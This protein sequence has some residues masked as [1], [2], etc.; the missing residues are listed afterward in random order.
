MHVLLKTRHGE[1]I[2]HQHSMCQVKFTAA[3]CERPTPLRQ[4]VEWA[5]DTKGRTA[6][7]TSAWSGVIEMP[8]PCGKCRTYGRMVCHCARSPASE[9]CPGRQSCS[10]ISAWAAL[11]AAMFCQAPADSYH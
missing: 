5:A 7:G 1:A 11:A 10:L 3:P 9:G 2:T 8:I 4:S 6:P